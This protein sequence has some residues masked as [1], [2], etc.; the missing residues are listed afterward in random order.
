M[1]KAK[2]II[3][4]SA[5][6]AI[7][8]AMSEGEKKSPAKFVSTFYT[9][10]ALSISGWD[11]PV[12]V[13]LAGL[14]NGNVL[15]ANLDHDA[16][17]RVGNFSVANDGRSLV[18]NG[19]ATASTAARDE[20]VQSAA[21]GYQWQASL[22]VSPKRVE[23]VKAGKKVEVNGQSFEGPLYVTRAGVLKGF[24]FVSHGADD[25]TTATIAASAANQKKGLHMKAEVKAWAESMG[26]DVEGASADQLATIEANFEGK[27]GKKAPVKASSDPFEARKLEAQRRTEI[28]AYADSMA[29]KREGDVEWINSIEAMCAHAIEAKMGVQ[30]FRIELQEAMAPQGFSVVTPRSRDNGISNRVLEAAVCMAGQMSDDDLVK[31]HRFTDQE[32]QTAHD[33]FKGRIGLKQLFFIAAEA[34]GYRSQY[35][36]D[37]TPEVQ[38]AAFGYAGPRQIHGSGGFSTLS[39]STILSNVANKFMRDGFNSVDQTCL[40]ISA[41]RNVTDFKTIT[42]TSLTDGVIFEKVGP[43]GEIKHGTLGEITYSNKADTYAKMLAITRTDYIN[44][45]MGALTLTPKKLGNGAMK[46]LNDIFWIEHL[47]LVG[48]NFFATGNANINTGAADMT[49]AGLKATETIFMNQTNPDGTPLGL[50]PAILLVPTALKYDAKALTDPTSQLITGASATLSN[51]NPFRG[52]FRVESSPYISNASYTGYTSV[53]W[54]MLA[55][56]ADMPVIEIAALNGR[57]EPTVETADAEFNVLGVQMR[58]YSDVGVKR[59]EYRG[60]VYA[61][62]GAS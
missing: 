34:N 25:N 54:W 12:V 39:I 3:A 14:T 8:A 11:L 22:E 37:I 40:R 35:S 4:M 43:A 10:G 49:V 7:E 2:Q 5:P 17:K 6:V 45:D 21:D 58:G 53:G 29:A 32:L 55:N 38:N 20:V 46:K 51:A 60:G 30:E 50:E 28:Q 23:E 57:I 61:D 27:N 18:A 44:D 1:A 31:K 47:A 36:S 19:T 16:S 9:G 62:G 33:K 56:P 42:T 26:I 48:A 52:R 59:Q 41:I 24:A 15:V 13:D